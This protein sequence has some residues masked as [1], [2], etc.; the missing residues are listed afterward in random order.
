MKSRGL[1]FATAVLAILGGVLYWSNHHKPTES[2]QASVD[3]PPKIL[4]LNE[5]DINRLEFKK[6]DD[7]ELV[8]AKDGGG[9]W[10][11][12]APQALGA[13]Q[14]AVSGVV[15]SLSSLSSDRLVEEKAADLGQFGLASPKLEVDITAKNNQLRKLLIGDETPAS[16]GVYA[17]LE[18]DPRVFT[19][20]S[21]TK[22][23]LD[24]SIINTVRK[25]IITPFKPERSAADGDLP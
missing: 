21:Y 18:N 8:I 9:N 24:K 12:I 3:A 20:A 1:I 4:T 2:V 10:Q 6:K 16:S 13:D 5:A 25:K 23:N 14:S 22:N 7:A 17:K 15:S 11:I 19:I